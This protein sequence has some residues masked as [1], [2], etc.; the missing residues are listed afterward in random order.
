MQTNWRSRNF[1]KQLLGYKFKFDSQNMIQSLQY[2][3][4]KRDYFIHQIVL[5][6]AN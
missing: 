3:L 4:S 2:D 1:V 6:L 5:L